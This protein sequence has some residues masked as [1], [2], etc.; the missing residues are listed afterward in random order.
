MLLFQGLLL[1]SYS[2][3]N[4]FNNEYNLVSVVN[5]LI[6]IAKDKDA[7][8]LFSKSESPLQNEIY[9]VKSVSFTGRG[10]L[11]QNKTLN[12]KIYQFI[13]VNEASKFISNTYFNPSAS[14]FYVEPIELTEFKDEAYIHKTPKSKN[15]SFVLR[16][17]N[18]VVITES[19]IK[20]AKRYTKYIQ[21]ELKKQENFNSN[22][23][24]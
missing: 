18:I 17:N 16:R 2:Q 14:S 4:N 20:E 10:V 7:L 6:K 13:N 8:R 3:Q 23:K 11:L 21:N 5:N 1:K 19:T 15:A 24:N 22:S 9:S 12:I